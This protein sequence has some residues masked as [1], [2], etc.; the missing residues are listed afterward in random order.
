MGGVCNE[1]R[2]YLHVIDRGTITG[3]RYRDE[4]L[5]PIVRPFAGAM[6]DRFVLMQ[7]N[8]RPHTARVSLNFLEEEGIEVMDWPARSPDLNPIEHVWDILRRRVVQRH[9]PPRVVLDLRRALVEEWDAI[10]Q[11]DIQ[12]PIQ[13]MPKRCLEC[14]QARGGH[15][16]Y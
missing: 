9:H 13:S 11:N 12:R 5:E 6:G 4:I 10:P 3:I 7:D 8:A 15:T 16:H 1:G 2:T 14:I